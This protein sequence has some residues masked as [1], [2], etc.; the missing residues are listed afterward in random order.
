MS[1]VVDTFQSGRIAAWTISTPSSLS[2]LARVVGV[3]REGI[4]GYEQEADH[5]DHLAE[6]DHALLDQRG[7]GLEQL[8]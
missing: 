1:Q 5:V 2:S 4:L 6:G 3:D 7:D 8:R